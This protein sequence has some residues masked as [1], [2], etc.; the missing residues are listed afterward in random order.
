VLSF[1]N[2]TIQLHKQQT[3]KLLLMAI[4]SRIVL[5]FALLAYVQCLNVL[6]QRVD[7][8][9]PDGSGVAFVQLQA[10]PSDP[11]FNL[12][13]GFSI[14]SFNFI[15]AEQSLR[16]WDSVADD[17]SGA[18]LSSGSNTVP[19]DG[20][21]CFFSNISTGPA[22]FQN[23]FNFVATGDS[24]GGNTG[25]VTLLNYNKQLCPGIPDLGASNTIVPPPAPTASITLQGLEIHFSVTATYLRNHTAWCKYIN[26]LK[27]FYSL[28]HHFSFSPP[29]L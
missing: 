14:T 10:D 20:K 19:A 21:V 13:T 18:L 22:E 11:N 6:N 7:I 25:T 3:N 12:L 17:C 29:P 23:S 2:P 8:P 1:M 28:T 4:T 26:N 15:N 9:D 5:I 27:Y 16:L 24:S